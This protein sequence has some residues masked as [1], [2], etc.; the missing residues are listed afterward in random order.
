M[1]ENIE[2]SFKNINN[3]VFK[4]LNYVKC[5]INNYFKYYYILKIFCVN[6]IKLELLFFDYYFC[7]YYIKWL[8]RRRGI[9][10]IE[11]I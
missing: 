8:S 2:E 11:Y 5:I 7:F 1:I 4:N 6:F 9:E 10:I 3:N